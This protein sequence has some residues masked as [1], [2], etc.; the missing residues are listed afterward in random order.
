MV[1]EA[2]THIT[3]FHD[4]FSPQQC[5][6]LRA[7]HLSTLYSRFCPIWCFFTTVIFCMEA[8]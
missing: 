1:T 8:F 3:I 2:I 5:L 7:R 4:Y 6:N